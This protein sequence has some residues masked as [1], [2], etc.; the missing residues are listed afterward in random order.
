M[1]LL[2]S[3]PPHSLNSASLAR[4]TRAVASSTKR[5]VQLTR[6]GS[7]SLLPPF[8]RAAGMSNSSS[9]SSRK[10]FD[11]KQILRIRWRWFGHP[12]VPPP[13][14]QPPLGDYFSARRTGGG[15]ADG[16]SVSC[17]FTSAGGVSPP[18]G[19]AGSRGGLVASG[20]AG[21]NL[22]GGGRKFEPGAS[23]GGA[24]AGATGNSCTRSISQPECRSSAGLSPWVSP[25]PR[26]RSR[27]VTNHMEPGPGE[28][29]AEEPSTRAGAPEEAAAEE[30]QH[31][32]TDSSSCR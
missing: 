24:A 15:S 25:P 4:S 6:S 2:L 20:S 32:E 10:E 30:N 29:P 11:V 1:H 12:A 23:R 7:C 31:P 9:S 17:N 19:G 16:P 8:A 5:R 18:G 28:A 27:P 3:P 26:R 14:S 22:C 21:S 13:H